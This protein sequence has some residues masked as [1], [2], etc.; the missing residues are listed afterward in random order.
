[1]LKRIFGA[2]LIM[3]MCSLL[4]VIFAQS[5]EDGVSTPY[6]IRPIINCV[7]ESDLI[8]AEQCEKW[9]VVV[10]E[11][12]A[13]Y[14]FTL[15]SGEEA[16]PFDF[17]FPSVGSETKSA[18]ARK[19]IMCTVPNQI[20]LAKFVDGNWQILSSSFVEEF[21]IGSETL[22]VGAE[23]VEPGIY[24]VV[25]RVDNLVSPAEISSGNYC[26]EIAG[27]GVTGTF[28][29]NPPRI[30]L[31]DTVTLSFCGIVEG[32]DASNSAAIPDYC[33]FGNNE[34]F[35]CT[36]A[37]GDCCFIAK[38]GICDPDCWPIPLPEG[39]GTLDYVDPDCIDLKANPGCRWTRYDRVIESRTDACDKQCTNLSDF[40]CKSSESCTFKAGDC[41]LPEKGDGCDPD[42]GNRTHKL[43]DGTIVSS[44]VDPDCCN[45]F[46]VEAN[47]SAGNC[48]V[49]LCDGICDPDCIFGV[50]PD[51]SVTRC[52]RKNKDDIIDSQ[53]A[54]CIR[55][56]DGIC[57]SRNKFSYA[58]QYDGF[59]I[60]YERLIADQTRRIEDEGLEGEDA[61][62]YQKYIEDYIK[63]KEMYTFEDRANSPE[64]CA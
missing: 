12:I 51:C 37:E 39:P 33:P 11:P 57:D 40:E 54:C 28:A 29:T 56:G 35:S 63:Y 60:K 46:S 7:L 43:D 8:P 20:A 62:I 16:A 10:G 49:P 64:D 17:F 41:C 15:K 48:C 25:Q 58:D 21:P 50:D 32:C 53:A 4:L 18:F 38:D 55:H 26:Q 52:S 47:G 1:M 59:R 9:N 13:A 24:A 19:E 42:C 45:E 61:E 6:D 27:C 30:E 31:G 22:R 3:L 23:I 14:E 5:V 44:Y 34:I 2:F 36:S